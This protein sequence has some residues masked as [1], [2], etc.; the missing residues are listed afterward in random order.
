[1]FMVLFL[2]IGMV[3]LYSEEENQMP[4][5]REG[6]L[7]LG[8]S[9]YMLPLFTIEMVKLAPFGLSANY[10]VNDHLDLV[11]S[12]APLNYYTARIL[13]DMITAHKYIFIYIGEVGTRYHFSASESSFFIEADL[14]T[15]GIYGTSADSDSF[16]NSMRGAVYFGGGGLGFT[17]PVGSM[18]LAVGINVYYLLSDG[19]VKIPIPIVKASLLW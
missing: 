17:G 10:G 15:L 2:F 4:A 12:L 16:L 9:L 8:T 7:R 6:D 18:N 1:M 13:P 3:Q 19:V 5:V 11:G 14:S